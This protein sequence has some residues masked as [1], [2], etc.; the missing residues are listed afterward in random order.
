MINVTTPCNM[1]KL[2][3]DELREIYG[4]EKRQTVVL[5]LLKKAASCLQLQNMLANHLGTTR[6]QISRLEEI[7]GLLGRDPGASQSEAVLGIIRKAET[8]IETTEKGSATRDAGLV[9]TVQ[10]LKHYEISSYGSLAQWCRTLGYDDILD[11]LE[12]T[13]LEEKEAE[14][15]LTTLA[16]NYIN[17]EL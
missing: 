9:A 3:L 4:A 10:K 6:E 7:F 13:L 2:F 16:E 5:P 14:D 17:T 8:V 15:L 12:E 1:E 11:I